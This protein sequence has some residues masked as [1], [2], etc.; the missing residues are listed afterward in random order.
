[1]PL[2]F[3]PLVIRGKFPPGRTEHGKEVVRNSRA[4]LPRLGA[5]QCGRRLIQVYKSRGP[6]ESRHARKYPTRTVTPFNSHWRLMPGL[7]QRTTGYPDSYQQSFVHLHFAARCGPGL[8]WQ[9]QFEYLFEHEVEA[10]FALL[11]NSTNP[12]R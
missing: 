7:T 8:R 6:V 9:L 5:G 10:S 12:S 11:V 1:M 4:H 3:F 2:L